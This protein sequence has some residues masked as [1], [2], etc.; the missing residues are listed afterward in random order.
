MTLECQR[1]SSSGQASHMLIIKTRAGDELYTARMFDN[2]PKGRWLPIE[3]APENCDLE[4]GVVDKGGVAPC[5]FSCRR[6]SGFW[7]NVWAGEPVLIHP[8][9]WRSWRI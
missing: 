1:P 4:I 6:V 2:D 3:L 7:F 9:H 8:T 5:R